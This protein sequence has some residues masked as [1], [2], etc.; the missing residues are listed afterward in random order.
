M[1]IEDPSEMEG[2]GSLKKKGKNTNLLLR[3][4]LFLHS[5]FKEFRRLLET[6][7][8]IFSAVRKSLEQRKMSVLDTGWFIMQRERHLKPKFT[9]FIMKRRQ[10][11]QHMF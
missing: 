10:A 7:T 6:S 3:P 8:L 1:N 9:A 2:Q 4:L 5:P 11:V